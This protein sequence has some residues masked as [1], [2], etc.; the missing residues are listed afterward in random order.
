MCLAPFPRTFQA[1]LPINR[2]GGDL[3]PVIIT[4]ALALACC[5]AASTLL[6]MIWGGLKDFL[7][8]TTTVIF[9]QAAREGNRMGVSREAPLNAN[10]ATST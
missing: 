4:A 10:R 2:V 8:I 3:L 6:R 1:N 5:L 9:H 7:T